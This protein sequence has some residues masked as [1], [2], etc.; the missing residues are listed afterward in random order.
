MRRPWPHSYRPHPH[1]AHE[2][3]EPLSDTPL[4]PARDTS[5]DLAEDADPVGQSR[6]VPQQAAVVV[7]A[8]GSEAVRLVVAVDLVQVLQ[9]QRVAGHHTHTRSRE[10]IHPARDKP[11]P[12]TNLEW[13]AACVFSM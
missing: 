1:T 10:A 7:L 9:L 2:H 12:P 11:P 4:Q 3:K 13:V 5:T 8:P 6:A